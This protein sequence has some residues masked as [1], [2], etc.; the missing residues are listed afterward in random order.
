M[1]ARLLILTAGF[2]EGHNA[3]A[4]AIAAA[5][6]RC[7]GPGAALIVDAFALASPR[8]NAVLRRGYLA[9]INGTPRAW[10]AV[11]A[12]IDR[13]A[14]FPRALWL[15]RRETRVLE[16]IIAR[17]KPAVICSTYPV[18][19]FI[20]EKLVRE[21]RCNVPHFNVVTDSIS[22]NSLW[23][24]AGCT[25]WFLPNEDSA[26]V[27][28]HAGVEPGR[29]H[30]SGFPVTPFFSD[31]AD[32][33]SPP[34]LIAGAAPRVLYIINSGTK[35][36]AETARRLLAETNWEITCAVGRDE[37]L[38]RSLTRLASGR[39]RPARILGWTNQIP[40]LLM[41]H[42]VVVSKAGGATT[43]EAIAARCPMIVNQIVPGQEEGN[44]ELLRRHGIGALAETP[45]AVI[46]SLRHAFADRGRLWQHWREAL[47]PLAR[48]DAARTIADHLLS[49]P[50]P[51]TP[52]ATCHLLSDILAERGIQ[53]KDRPKTV[54]L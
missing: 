53:P 49:S 15:L 31:H 45:G 46:H 29:L 25:G 2:G 14:I 23:W 44:Y 17:E 32:E 19:A 41:T 18:Y 34:D 11:Y 30:V 6:D 8:A 12:W 7:H 48:P 21:G 47:V 52:P 50:F 28:R 5:S 33:F 54:A 51:P 22:L 1:S 26:E 43:Q 13:S 10:S 40:Q 42:H 39:A 27:L 4:R 20:I 24:R 9:M 35:N 16:A 3:A 36:A 38:R 37:G